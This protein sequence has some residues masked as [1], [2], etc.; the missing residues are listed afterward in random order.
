MV[1]CYQSLSVILEYIR[2]LMI[3]LNRFVSS[4]GGM[5]AMDE[6]TPGGNQAPTPTTVVYSPPQSVRGTDL[7]PVHKALTKSYQSEC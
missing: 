6:P 1:Y 7:E 4:Q 2:I 5:R 3:R